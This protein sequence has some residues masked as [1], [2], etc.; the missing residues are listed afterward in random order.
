MGFYLFSNKDLLQVLD[1]DER[2]WLLVA[3]CWLLA[4]A[5]FF[6]ALEPGF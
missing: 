1:V 6:T 4:G 5:S 3:G 2:T